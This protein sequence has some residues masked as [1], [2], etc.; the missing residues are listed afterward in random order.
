MD[1]SHPPRA[2]VKFYGSAISRARPPSLPEP[3]HDG[4]D[5]VGEDGQHVHNVHAVLQELALARGPQKPGPPI[6]CT[7]TGL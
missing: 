3:E 5:K 7:L 4:G 1:A 2:V 6:P